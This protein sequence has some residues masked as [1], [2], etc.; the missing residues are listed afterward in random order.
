MVLVRLILVIL[1]IFTF[2]RFY[3]SIII[4]TL[5]TYGT[6]PKKKTP[7]N[8]TFSQCTLKFGGGFLHNAYYITFELTGIL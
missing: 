4:C 1:L 6:G 7:F 8:K 2:N 3:Y 5:N